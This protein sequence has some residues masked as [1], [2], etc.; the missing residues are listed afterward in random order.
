LPLSSS[1]SHPHPVILCWQASLVSW[2][3]G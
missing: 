1:F 2:N 3:N